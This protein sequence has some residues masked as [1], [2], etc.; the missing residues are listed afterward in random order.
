MNEDLWGEIAVNTELKLPVAILKSQA[1]LLDQKTNGI[2]SAQVSSFK[3]TG[4]DA[5]GY[6][7]NIVAPD[8]SNYVFKLLTVSHPAILLYPVR[9]VDQVSKADHTC[10]T[11]E[12]FISAV[13][14]ILSSEVVHKAI[15]A[16]ITQ[17]RA[18][19]SK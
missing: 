3:T 14:Q 1:L 19:R 7:F 17:S 4:K 12:E 15:L 10:R 13:R 6:S 5:V 11:E 16:L 18:A 9:V 2:L 8:L